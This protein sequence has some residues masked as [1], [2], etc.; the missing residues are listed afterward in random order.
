ML[1]TMEN[2]NIEVVLSFNDSVRKTYVI[3]NFIERKNEKN[4]KS[5]G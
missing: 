3:K 5:R 2:K 1:L 4:N